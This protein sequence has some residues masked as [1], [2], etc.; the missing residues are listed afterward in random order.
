[1]PK[2]I[3]YSIATLALLAIATAGWLVH[4]NEHDTFMAECM[5]RSTPERCQEAW[6]ARNGEASP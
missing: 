5:P 2:L 6:G 4:G 1:M 3:R